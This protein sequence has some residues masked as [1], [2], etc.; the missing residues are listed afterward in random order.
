MASDQERFDAMIKLLI[1]QK[2]LPKDPAV[3]S[4]TAY[5]EI[6]DCF[7]MKAEQPKKP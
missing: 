1:I 6:K 3:N 5:N 7:F 4:P 2:I